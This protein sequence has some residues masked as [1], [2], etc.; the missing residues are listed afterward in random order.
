[1]TPD[2]FDAAVVDSNPTL[3][4]VLVQLLRGMCDNGLVANLHRERWIGHVMEHRLAGLSPNLR[5]KVISCL[6]ILHDRH[7]LVRHPRRMQGEPTADGE[8]LE[9]AL[10]SHRR[11]PFHEI[12]LGKNLWAE[13]RDIDVAFT[14]LAVALDSPQ[15]QSRRRS[16]TLTKC[17]AD[18]RVALEHFSLQ[19]TVDQSR[20][21]SPSRP[22]AL[23]PALSRR[24]RGNSA[25]TSP[26]EDAGTH[27]PLP[28][29]P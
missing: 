8:W 2:V 1:M 20:Q 5:D 9:L 16:S 23:T 19:C 27:R 13:Y 29:M 28:V 21:A 24:E 22:R 18:Y 15:W 3:G 14:E 12:I 10:E 6:K 26:R 7:R 25:H 17:D 11:L 4:V